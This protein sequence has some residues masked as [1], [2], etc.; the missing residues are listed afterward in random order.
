MMNVLALD[1]PVKAPIKLELR[2][3]QE[4]AVE[5]LREGIRRGLRR[6]LLCSPTGSGKTFIAA[7]MAREA[8]QRGYRVAFVVD[9]IALADQTSQRFSEFGIDHGVL[10]GDNTRNRDAPVMVCSA[11][12]LEK[13]G[14]F[15]DLDLLFVDECHAQ[16]KATTEYLMR[17]EKNGFIAVGLTATPFT[18]GLGKTWQ[19]CVTTRPTNR[20]IEDG[21]IVRPKV[22]RGAEPDMRGARTSAGEWTK[23][24]VEERGV[25]IL[26]DIVENWIAKSEIEFGGPAKTLVFSATVAHG[27]AVCE[28]FAQSGYDFRQISYRDA[29]DARRQRLI[30]M[31]E[32]GDITGLVSCEALA[33]GFD[34]PDTRILISARP[35]KASLAAHVQQVGRVMRASPGKEFGLVLDHAGNWMRFREDVAEFFERGP[36]ETLDDG[37]K[38]KSQ[39]K[40]RKTRSI[41]CP[42]CGFVVDDAEADVCPA[43]G[44]GLRRRRLEVVTVDANLVLD[45]GALDKS[46]RMDKTMRAHVWGQACRIAVEKWGV[47]DAEL[48][49]RK[50]SGYYKSFAHEW[51]R[52]YGIPLAPSGRVDAVIDRAIRRRLRI[53]RDE[54]IAKQRKRLSTWDGGRL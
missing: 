13:R 10:Q 52:P 15:P 24:A 41:D 37:E 28:E 51:P 45:D 27:E 2:E 22:Y 16:R 43:C 4:R 54:M 18:R 25:V 50:A 39:S 26:G 21:W 46:V 12:T 31:Y 3:Y 34:V 42:A 19:R 35:Y 17:A 32:R 5:E 14:F 30:E 29:N 1:G 48:T 47:E 23:S 44:A 11:Q 36:D 40:R 38:P 8:A 9:R 20:L 49:R 6:Q 33:K 7:W 53:Y